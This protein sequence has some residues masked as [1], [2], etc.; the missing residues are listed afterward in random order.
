LLLTIDP[1]PLHADSSAVGREEIVAR[2]RKLAIDDDTQRDELIRLVKAILA[3]AGVV[4]P[5]LNAF[6]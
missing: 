1:I 2:P 4:V 3:I 6:A 5:R